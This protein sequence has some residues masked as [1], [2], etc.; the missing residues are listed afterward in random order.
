ML[1]CL[2]KS[3]LLSLSMKAKEQTICP[4]M[5]LRNPLVSTALKANDSPDPKLGHSTWIHRKSRSQPE[6]KRGKCNF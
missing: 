2:H 3:T 1:N 6:E 4:V 5:L